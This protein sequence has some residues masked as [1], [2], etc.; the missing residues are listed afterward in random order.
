[1]RWGVVSTIKAPLRDIAN[2]AAHHLEIGAH[3]IFIYLDDD[4]QP[5][6]DALSGHPRLTL[7]KA[8]AANWRNA[9]R[10]DKHQPRQSANA[11]HALKRK[12]AG[13]DWLAHIDVD[14]FIWPVKPLAEQL[15][16]LPQDCLCARIRPV[17]ALSPEGVA[18][19]PPGLTH[20]KATALKRDRRNAETGA[21][22]PTFGPHLNGGFLSHV[23]GKMIFRTG[24][25]GL[26]PRIHNVIL[27]DVQNPG[28]QELSQAE[29][30]HLHAPSLNDWL[31]RFDYRLEK[32]AYRAELAPTR[33]RS[34]GGLTMHELFNTILDEHGRD[35][36][37]AFY[38]EVCRATPD[39]RARLEAHG[40]LR[41]YALDLDA[42]RTKHFPGLA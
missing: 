18:D 5:A 21:I 31:S 16:A 23:A 27:G 15:Q 10:P 25:D 38:D 28:Q 14:E 6:L 42:K 22:Y 41:S 29:L 3:R 34:R 30:L 24:I 4:N 36:L 11:R 40:L 17:E 37:H 32:G 8:D 33:A 2:F 1:M 39:L 12:S 19:I 35:G 13:L 9:K 20:F 7:I 26:S